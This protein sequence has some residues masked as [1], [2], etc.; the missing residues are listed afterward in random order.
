MAIHLIS[1]SIVAEFNLSQLNNSFFFACAR[2]KMRNCG[3]RL[4]HRA[5]QSMVLHVHM[6]VVRHVVNL[7]DVKQFVKTCDYL[8]RSKGSVPPVQVTCSMSNCLLKRNYTLTWLCSKRRATGIK[9]NMTPIL[10]LL[11]LKTYLHEQ[12]MCTT[13]LQKS[14]IKAILCCSTGNT[15]LYASH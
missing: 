2:I 10:F 6:T 13:Y 11:L 9:A 15:C 4:G 12:N 5:E 7:V 1:P 3:R 8:L 14:K